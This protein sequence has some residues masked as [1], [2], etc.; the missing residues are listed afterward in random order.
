MSNSR[1]KFIRQTS[2][3]VLGA[4]LTTMLPL[5]AI[6]QIRRRVSA[7]DKINLG[8]IGCKGMGWSNMNAL[9]TNIP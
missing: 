7:N 5:D 1:R 3:A 4:G 9:L 8:L 6:A 2:A